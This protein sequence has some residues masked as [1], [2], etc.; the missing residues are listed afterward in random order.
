MISDA[1]GQE[2]IHYCYCS[3]FYTYIYL[4]LLFVLETWCS[5]RRLCASSVELEGGA[6]ARHQGQQHTQIP[7]R[8]LPCHV[9]RR[10]MMNL[11]NTFQHKTLLYISKY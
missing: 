8:Y 9:G 7:G 6:R 1:A 5:S 2:T 3:F 4:L 11:T 10:G